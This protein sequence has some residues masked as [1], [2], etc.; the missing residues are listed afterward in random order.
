MKKVIMSH[1]LATSCEGEKI[2]LVIRL[3]QIGGGGDSH[4]LIIRQFL[5]PLKKFDVEK[6]KSLFISYNNN[7]LKLTT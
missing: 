5:R 3:N 6:I 4:N 2:S 1:P 7:L